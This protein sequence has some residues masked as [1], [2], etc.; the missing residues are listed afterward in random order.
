MLKPSVL[1]LGLLG[2]TQQV[3]VT[4]AGDHPAEVQAQELLGIAVAQGCA[5]AVEHYIDGYHAD[6]AIRATY[7]RAH[8]DLCETDTVQQALDHR[9]WH[10]TAD[11]FEME[12]VRV[13]CRPDPDDGTVVPFAYRTPDHFRGENTSISWGTIRV[14]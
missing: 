12:R 7:A 10:C 14:G 13:Q 3:R 1:M 4:R 5:A 2:C 9:E 8:I 6:P 11:L